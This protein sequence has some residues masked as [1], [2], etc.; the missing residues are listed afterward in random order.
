MALINRPAG[1]QAT[2][3]TREIATPDGG[4]TASHASEG[5]QSIAG[6]RPVPG[7][8]EAIAA[9][10]AEV[11]EDKAKRTYTKPDLS[12]ITLEAATATPLEE[13]DLATPP[14]V[15]KEADRSDVQKLVDGQY[16]DAYLAWAEAGRPTIVRDCYEHDR[17]VQLDY[18][19]R[20]EEAPHTQ[21]IVRRFFLDPSQEAAFRVLIRKAAEFSGHGVKILPIATHQSG[22]HVLVWMPRDVK[23][24]TAEA[25]AKLAAARAAKKSKDATGS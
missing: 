2:P 14:R 17:K 20:G 16:S 13:A 5:N 12:V 22:R 1:K 3:Q 25:K 18:R 9:V 21:L 23:E 19:Q 8:P 24:R 6:D 15:T 10:R 11:A 7:S 4:M